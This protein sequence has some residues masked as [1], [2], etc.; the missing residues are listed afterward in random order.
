MNKLISDLRNMVGSSRHTGEPIDTERVAAA[1]AGYTSQHEECS[2]E[3]PEW[4]RIDESKARHSYRTPSFGIGYGSS[5]GYG[6]PHTDETVNATQYPAA[7]DAALPKP[8]GYLIASHIMRDGLRFQRNTPPAGTTYRDVY[9]FD[10][11]VQHG[12]ARAALA[13]PASCT[14]PSGDGSL[15]W[16]CPE[17]PEAAP[18]DIAHL[19]GMAKELASNAHSHSKEACRLRQSTAHK[20]AHELRQMSKENK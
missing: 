7:G 9:T 14:C 15:I 1:I 16:P 3:D 20:L 13:P 5:S 4:V 17:H 6:M 18:V 10:K 8:F 19:A 11:L 2:K 12:D